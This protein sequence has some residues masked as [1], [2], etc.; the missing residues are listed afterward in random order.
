MATSSINIRVDEELKKNANLLF[1]KLGL[2]MSTAINIF[3]QMAVNQNGLPFRVAL[4]YNKETLEAFEEANDIAN[5]PEQ[6]KSYD[7]FNELMDEVL[8]KDA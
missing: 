4:N 3:L 5:H 7:S 8:A 6:Y 1:S 2:N